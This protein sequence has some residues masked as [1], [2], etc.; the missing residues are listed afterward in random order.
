MPV[1]DDAFWAELVTGT[2]RLVERLDDDRQQQLPA[3]ARTLVHLVVHDLREEVV[4][5]LDEGGRDLRTLRTTVVDGVVRAHLPLTDRVPAEV[6]ERLGVLAPEETRLSTSVRAVRWSDDRTLEVE[7]WAFVENVDLSELE[8]HVRLELHEQVGARRVCVPL[9]PVTDPELLRIPR[10]QHCRY[11][12]GAFRARLDAGALGA[13]PEGPAPE[14]A[15]GRAEGRTLGDWRFEVTVD[16]AGVHR[17]GPLRSAYRAGSAGALRAQ[18]QP[19]GLRVAPVHSTAGLRIEVRR[20]AVVAVSLGLHD[21]LLRVEME[22]REGAAPTALVARDP[23]GEVRRSQVSASDGG[24]W[25]ASLPILPARSRPRDDDRALSSWTL[26]VEDVDG[27]ERPVAWPLDLPV[28]RLADPVDPG[29]DVVRTRAGNVGLAELADVVLVRAARVVGEE[30]E[31]EV[32]VRGPVRERP[33]F[34][35]RSSRLGVPPR[36]V[37]ESG[38]GLRLVFPLEADEWGFGTL[39]LPVGEYL[40]VA[41]RNEPGGTPVRLRQQVDAEALAELPRPLRLPR[42]RGR[43]ERHPAGDLRL[44]L[45]PP[46]AD[47]ELGAWHQRRLQDEHAHRRAPTGARGRLPHLLRRGPPP[48]PR[49]PCTSSCAA[50]RRP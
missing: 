3:A 38:D 8:P 29:L 13:S 12:R 49:S 15:S 27:R 28:S 11:D 6:R 2:R 36:L 21:R 18:L 17:S 41:A 34:T 33:D 19:D 14:T 32:V 45:D 4:D 30:L 25:T 39:P 23:G 35:L 16:V 43:L 7:F 50:A 47:D 44:A 24:R 9:E 37:E 40:L 31:V 20:P 5:F 46:L 22:V 10:H 1:A 42:L 48:T 26:R